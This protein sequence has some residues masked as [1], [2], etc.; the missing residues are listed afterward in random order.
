VILSGRRLLLILFV[1][2]LPLVT[3]KIRGADEI[4]YYSHLRSL[5]FD[6]DLDFENEYSWFVAQDP[7]GLAAFRETFLER[8]EPRTGRPINFT[9]VGCALLWSPFYLLVHAG[10]LALRALGAPLVADGFSRPYQ[11][12][13]CYASF[14]YGGLGLLLLHAV[15][16]RRFAEPMAA[17]AVAAIWLASPLLYYMTLAPGFSHASSVFAVCLLLWLSL[18]ARERGGLAGWALAG[19]A[20]GLC[21]LIRE[22]DAL[23]LAI[24]AGLLLADAAR[25]GRVGRALRP[26]ALLALAAAAMLGPQLLAYRALNGSFRPTTLVTRKLS[27]LSPHF[28]DVLLDPGHGLFLW[29]PLLALATAGLVYEA[30]R[31]REALSAVLLLALLL[32]M[33]INGA[34][35]SW[36]QAG[37]F[38]SRRFV[39]ASALFAFGLAALLEAWDGR[40]AWLAGSLALFVWWNVSLMV[41]FGLKLMDRQRLEWPRVAINQFTEVPRLLGRTARLFFSDRE[42]LVK[43]TR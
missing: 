6:G 9:P 14:F 5:V 27:L 13:A 36:H 17:W 31:R 35:L 40:R 32:Q 15:L 37:A 3:P 29:S 18:R 7:Q 11:A 23:F 10:V 42:R 39:A 30:W 21:G 38:G 33:W 2:T 8:R 20:G 43:E 26:L 1:L 25:D 41:Q 28:L 16:R 19:L 12:A 22:Q 4:Q 34:V 24:P